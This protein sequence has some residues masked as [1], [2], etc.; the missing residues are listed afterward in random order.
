MIDVTHG[1]PVLVGQIVGRGLGHSSC[2][3][4]GLS[5]ELN[6]LFPLFRIVQGGGEPQQT[7]DLESHVL[8]VVGSFRS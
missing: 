8:D 4:D 5:T 6:L 7:V 2:Q 1:Q 3:L